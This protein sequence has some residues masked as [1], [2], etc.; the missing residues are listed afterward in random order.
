MDEP[1][2]WGLFGAM[3]DLSREME[4]FSD[5][6]ADDLAM[7]LPPDIDVESFD[8]EIELGA[9]QPS[10]KSDGHTVFDKAGD[11]SSSA[12]TECAKGDLQSSTL[13]LDRMVSDASVHA[14][15]SGLKLPWELECFDSLFGSNSAG[16]ILPSV[17]PCFSLA[18]H[19]GAK[20]EKNHA[21]T[22]SSV[23]VTS[24]KTYFDHAVSMRVGRTKALKYASQLELLVKRF[25]ALVATDFDSSTVGKKIKAMEWSDRVG[26]VGQC[27]SGR[28]LN[29]LKKR[30]GQVAG[31]LR[32][33]GREFFQMPFPFEW[34]LMRAYLD[35][36]ARKGSHSAFTGFLEVV[37]F[38]QHV[39]GYYVPDGFFTDPWMKGTM[40]GLRMKR[41][42]RRQSR[43]LKVSELKHLESFL[44]NDTKSLV[45]RF[46]AGKEVAAYDLGR[47][48]G[49]RWRQPYCTRAQGYYPWD[50][51]SLRA[52]SHYEAHFG[53]SLDAWPILFGD[54]LQRRTS[55]TPREYEPMMDPIRK[56]TYV[57]DATRS[58]LIVE[59]PA[60]RTASTSTAYLLGKFDRNLQ[61]QVVGAD[62][63]EAP[64][65]DDVLEEGCFSDNPA[66]SSQSSST[67]TDSSTDDELVANLSRSTEQGATW[68]EGCKV[69]QHRRTKAIHA[70][71]TGSSGVFLCGQ[72]H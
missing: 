12:P 10:V 41:P 21:A 4:G 46:A 68:K 19:P 17:E 65:N 51:G 25:E 71:A 43:L 13:I 44:S 27:L 50:D 67:S 37:A 15:L 55:C 16:Q 31:Y 56:G 66:E 40:R 29:T 48:G 36:L 60:L 70:M 6:E 34:D 2:I 30:Y 22:Q 39:L 63:V 33:V 18:D 53:T 61:E 38:M 54:L 32:F 57:P 59:K 5:L 62:E 11:S 3:D 42:P 64:A 58:G 1:S 7:P 8:E 9:P 49:L 52:F 69:F 14:S 23:L 26:Y 20:S 28:S 47:N 35:H 72:H 24:K 45:D